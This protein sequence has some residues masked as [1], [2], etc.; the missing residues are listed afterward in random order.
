MG[1]KEQKQAR[2]DVAAEKARIQGQTDTFTNSLA[3]ERA[4]ASQRYN[5]GYNDLSNKYSGLA[6]TGGIDPTQQAMLRK[7]FGNLSTTGG[8]DPSV[9][10]RIGSGY[11]NF[12]TTGGFAPGEIANIRARSNSAIPAVYSRLQE[13]LRSQMS[14]QGGYSPGY[15]ALTAK[16][17]RQAAESA[18]TTARDTETGIS[19]RIRSGKLAG[20]QGETGLQESLRQGRTTGLAGGQTLEESIRAGKLGGFGGLQQL[21]GLALNERG[22]VDA[23]KLQAMGLN[24]GQIAQMMEQQ[25]QLSMTP[26][27]FD[28]IIRGVG[29]GAGLA[30]AFLPGPKIAK[31]FGQVPGGATA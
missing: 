23:N 18:A 10:D 13:G 8:F 31:G 4:L 21:M 12:S 5:T 7:G 20:L 29:A 3:P 25:R 2:T 27:I 14:R 15:G 24:A 30:S 9:A 28:N 22:Q 6:E 26:G 17:G 11:A 19:D 1:K 16:L